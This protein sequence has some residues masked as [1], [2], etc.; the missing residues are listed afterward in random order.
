MLKKYINNT[1]VGLGAVKGSSATIKSITP[2]D[3]GNE[4]AFE[5]VGTDNSKNT[6]TLF[7]KDGVSPTIKEA[8]DNSDSTYKLVIENS[9]GT[10]I[11]TPNL[12]G[13]DGT[14]GDGNGSDKNKIDIIQGIL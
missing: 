5:W 1:L 3:G 13:K 10:I 11:T 7:V 9:D 12:K 14:N 4:V 6:S 2:I 8:D